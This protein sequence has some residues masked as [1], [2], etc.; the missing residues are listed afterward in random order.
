MCRHDSKPTGYKP[1]LLPAPSNSELSEK[2]DA[3]APAKQAAGGSVC[4]KGT[5]RGPFQENFGA[6]LE[7]G[8]TFTSGTA[9]RPGDCLLETPELNRIARVPR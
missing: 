1:A 4:L 3:R 7:E 9:N 5:L 8:T 2:S 6:E